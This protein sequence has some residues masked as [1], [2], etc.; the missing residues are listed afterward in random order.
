MLNPPLYRRK[1][2]EAA[3]SPARSKRQYKFLKSVESGTAKDAH[4]LTK[5]QAAEFTK[6]Q[7]PKDLPETA[8]KP[9]KPAKKKK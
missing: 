9:A 6:G 7:S 1:T 5:K 2:A 3:M 4:G 8:K